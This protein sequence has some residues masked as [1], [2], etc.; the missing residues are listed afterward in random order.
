M[1]Q[2][3]I[4]YMC[5]RLYAAIAPVA[6]HHAEGRRRSRYIIAQYIYIYIYIYIH[7]HVYV[8]VCMYVD[9]GT[10]APLIN[11]DFWFDLPPS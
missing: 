4:L 3:N 8:Y 6:A 2:Y 5:T 11:D 7:V 9:G 1:L 10:I